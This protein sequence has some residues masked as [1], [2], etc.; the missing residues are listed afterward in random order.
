MY[1]R[2]N[3][4]SGRCACHGPSI[5]QSVFVGHSL[6]SSYRFCSVRY[7]LQAPELVVCD[8]VGYMPRINPV[9]F[10]TQANLQNAELYFPLSPAAQATYDQIWQRFLQGR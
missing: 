5:C 3:T 7:G 1:A 8:R 2:D 10:P 4:W 6:Q 9:I